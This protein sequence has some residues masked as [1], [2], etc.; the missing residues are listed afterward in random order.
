MG[1]PVSLQG[2]GRDKMRAPAQLEKEARALD[3]IIKNVD[4]VVGTMSGLGG[5]S[6]EVAAAAGGMRGWGHHP[7]PCSF[8]SIR[9][10]PVPCP[11]LEPWEKLLPQ[12]PLPSCSCPCSGRTHLYPPMC[13]CQ[14]SQP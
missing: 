11:G 2:E 8:P 9:V 3:T 5:L 14:S 4:M 13:S 1:T 10:L 12:L 7:F 6:M